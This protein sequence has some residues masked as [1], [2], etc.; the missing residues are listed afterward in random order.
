[1]RTMRL[2]IESLTLVGAGLATLIVPRHAS[3]QV[4]TQVGVVAG[5]VTDERGV[6]SN[7]VSVMPT[8]VLSSDRR[9][10]LWLSGTATRFESAGWSLGG[11]ATV[12]ARA[13]VGKGAALSLNAGGGAS[14]S[15][16]GATFVVAEATPAVEWSLKSL[17][18]FGGA[19][20]AS[21]IVNVRV[22]PGPSQPPVPLPG[23]T[24]LV[25]V[26]RTS[27]G[28]VYGAVWQLPGLFVSSRLVL[29]Y[30]EERG[31]IAGVTA[32]DRSA[33]ASLAL[34]PVGIGGSLGER[35]GSDARVRF[36]SGNVSLAIGPAVSLQAAGGRYPSDRL[37]GA[38]G[39]RFL[40]A[41]LAFK[42]GGGTR[43]ALPAPRGVQ[44]PADG[45]TRLSIR[46]ADAQ[47]VD[48]YG[49]WNGWTPVAARR[50][51]N[52]VWYVDIPLAPGEYRY[53]FRINQVEWRVPDG[54][55]SANDGFGGR[56][57]YVTVKRDAASN[58]T[59]S[60]EDA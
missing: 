23:R 19:R 40:S 5:S 20:V 54:A 6:I 55:V 34:G 31:V 8:I 21:G 51:E 43:N 41:G 42:F 24:T 9:V 35:A 18:M 38:A 36:A 13:D 16:F 12:A 22:E 30:R 28:P 45:A 50:A 49:D 33:A 26:T 39:G 25:S 15:S 53:A 37:T 29:S 48:I 47:Q 17:T 32:I 7:A 3:A 52:G 57:A 11:S 4:T 56:S 27:R 46:A 58:G 44:R 59:G 1:M 60:Q 14:R 2:L 10:G